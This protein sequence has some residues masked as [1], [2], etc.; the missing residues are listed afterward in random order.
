MKKLLFVLTILLS[1]TFNFSTASNYGLI[2]MKDVSGDWYFYTDM[3]KTKDCL[4]ILYQINDNSPESLVEYAGKYPPLHAP[5]KISNLKKGDKIRFIV[6]MI[7]N[8][9][10]KQYISST[11]YRYFKFEILGD[12]IYTYRFTV[13]KDKR[14][15]VQFYFYRIGE[16]KNPNS[17]IW[18]KDFKV[19]K[20]DDSI[21]FSG[22]FI[23]T[24]TGKI[25]SRIILRDENWK[26]QKILYLDSFVSEAGEHS[27]KYKW[28]PPTSNLRYI[29]IWKIELRGEKD[30]RIR[31]LK[32]CLENNP[33]EKVV[34]KDTE[35][36]KGDKSLN[37]KNNKNIKNDTQPSESDIRVV[38]G[39]VEVNGD[40]VY[41]VENPDC[42]CRVS[43]KVLGDIKDELKKLEGK[44]IKVKGK[45]KKFTPWSGT[46]EIVKN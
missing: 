37:S 31:E 33:S 35:Y 15:D 7:D 42:K 29:A 14:N 9:G 12:G 4:K 32:Y 23:N 24:K 26:V 34:N 13:P 3:V 5:I 2:D 8:N 18:I 1:F 16:G 44:I 10:K 41:I 22:N 19:Y 6:E 39:K 17:I 46:I 20:S 30:S 11:D 45:I 43:Y 27:I 36:N 21:E 38:E 25:K 40:N 28:V